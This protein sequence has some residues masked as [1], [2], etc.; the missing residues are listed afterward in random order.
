MRYIDALFLLISV[1]LED[2]VDKGEKMWYNRYGMNKFSSYS[3][4]IHAQDLL[5]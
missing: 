5:L 1:K 3:S 2:F 4:M